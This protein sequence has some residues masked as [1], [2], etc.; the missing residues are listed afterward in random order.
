MVRYLGQDKL[1]LPRKV[2]ELGLGIFGYGEL[3]LMVRC[4]VGHQ[5]G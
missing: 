5:M 3:C 2:K 1:V 4:E